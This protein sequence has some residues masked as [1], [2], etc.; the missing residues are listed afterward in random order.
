[1]M[2]ACIVETEHSRSAF[3]YAK[4]QVKRFGKVIRRMHI[5]AWVDH[6]GRLP[7]PETPWILHHC[8]NPPCIN[9]EHLYEGTMLDNIRDR[10]ER[11]RYV[12]W[13]AEKTHCKHG[14]EFTP[15]NTYHWG[16][17]RNCKA[18]SANRLRQYRERLKAA[19]NAEVAT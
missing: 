17:R 13:Q 16:R 14:H 7:N 19:K 11:G 4:C 1:M 3:G 2:S 9:V 15:E 5:L 10:Q 8:D 6:H 12:N 18:C